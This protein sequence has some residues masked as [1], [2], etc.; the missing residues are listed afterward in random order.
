MKQFVFV[1]A[2]LG[3][4]AIVTSSCQKQNDDRTASS[5]A[6]KGGIPEGSPY[7][8]ASEPAG[9][10][11]VLNVK[12]AAKDGDD[13]LIVGRIGG[14]RDPFVK[15]RAS[16]TIVDPSLKPCN[17]RPDDDCKTP[18][19]YCCESSDD[20]AK[21][22]VLVKVVDERGATVQTN[23]R[24]LLGVEPLHTVVVRGKAKRDAD[25]NLIVLA[26]RLHIRRNQ[27]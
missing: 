2:I 24:E 8:L 6:N 9:A 22:S 18:W 26:S 21:A 16:F 4:A 10:K 20:L 13:V 1:C 12:Q 5:V 11:G 15:D 23:A 7:L 19:D 14:Q 25:G 27:P 17:E 3:L